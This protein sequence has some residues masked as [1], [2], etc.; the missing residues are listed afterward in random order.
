MKAL[1]AL[2]L[3]VLSCWTTA[4]SEQARTP[5][6]VQLDYQLIGQLPHSR[7]DFTQGLEIRDGVLYQG[8]GL[9]GR[10]RLQAF[11]LETGTLLRE[12]ALPEPY[13]GEGITVLGDRVMQLT[14]RGRGGIVYRRS[15]FTPL[16]VFPIAGEGWGLTND[17]TQLIYSDGSE[18]LRFLDP[19]SWQVTREVSVR[20]GSNPLKQLNELEWTPDG[21]WANVWRRDVLVR[22]DLDSGQVTGEVNLKALLPRNQRRHGEDV[23][24]GIAYNPADDSFWVTGKNWPLLFQLKIFDPTNP[25]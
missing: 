12:R 5:G 16:G 8:T 21:L 6:V 18:V 19:Q 13:F 14:W 15:D 17:G 11:D 24:N 4:A 22:I 10:S 7:R 9:V 3:G 1:L 25:P 23:L 20:R 2:T